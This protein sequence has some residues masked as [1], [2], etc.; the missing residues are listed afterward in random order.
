MYIPIDDPFVPIE[1]RRLKKRATAD[2]PPALDSPDAAFAALR[3]TLTED[4]ILTPHDLFKQ[5][6]C[7]LSKSIECA[8]GWRNAHEVSI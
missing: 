3:T 6:E 7:V 8:M 4:E 1:K 2:S 5:G